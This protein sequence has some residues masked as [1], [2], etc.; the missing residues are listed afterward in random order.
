MIVETKA[1]LESNAMEVYTELLS[2]ESMA[3]RAKAAR[4]IM[5]LR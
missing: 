3:I 1:A 4:D 2:H 5:D